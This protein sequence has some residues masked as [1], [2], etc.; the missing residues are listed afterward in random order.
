[1]NQYNHYIKDGYV[2]VKL[3]CESEK[4]KTLL[5]YI[6]KH[7]LT[8]NVKQKIPKQL[9]QNKRFNQIDGILPANII[10]LLGRIK[11]KGFD[12]AIQKDS[13]TILATENVNGFLSNSLEAYEKKLVI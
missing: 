6:L 11:R 1:M 8:L 5:D 4:N 9:L 10:Q 12:L 3:E 2:F 7:T 13:Q